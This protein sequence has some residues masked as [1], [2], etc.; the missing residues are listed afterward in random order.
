[1]IRSFCT[2]L[3]ACSLNA[4]GGLAAADARCAGGC[5]VAAAGTTAE[6]EAVA[7]Q[8]IVVTARRRAED[9]QSVAA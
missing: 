8:E 7:L 3:I 1:M 5:A 9:L 6:N 2:A 4:V